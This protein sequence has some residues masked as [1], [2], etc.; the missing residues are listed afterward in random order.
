VL[1][2]GWACL[3]RVLHIYNAHH[4]L[5]AAPLNCLGHI[6]AFFCACAAAA[7]DCW[8][9][10]REAAAAVL[11]RMPTPLPGFDSPAALQPLLRRVLLLLGLPRG[12]ESDAGAQLLLLLLRKYAGATSEP[13]PGCCWRLNLATGTV[14]AAPA[15][16]A[17]RQR[18]GE[19]LW[20]FLSSACDLLQQRLQLAEGDMLE[21]CRGGLAQGV[22]LA[23]R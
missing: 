22:L 7:L 13:N 11:L 6:P 1:V 8:E 14:E 5:A 20:C 12:R 4:T 10:L 19:A 17:G 16:Q 23:I 21:A 18:Q 3:P 15:G 9:R 2:A